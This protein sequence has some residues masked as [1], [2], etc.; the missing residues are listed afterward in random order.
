VLEKHCVTD[1]VASCIGD[2][3]LVAP[4]VFHRVSN[5]LSAGCA[6][7]PCLTDAWVDVG[8]NLAAQRCK[9][10]H[11]VV[12]LSPE[13]CVAVIEGKSQIGNIV[14]AGFHSQAM[15]SWSLA[16]GETIDPPHRG[17]FIDVING[18]EVDGLEGRSHPRGWCVG[19]D[20]QEGTNHQG[21]RNLGGTKSGSQVGCVCCQDWNGWENQEGQDSGGQA[22]S[23]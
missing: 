6:W 22:L 19:P 21:P 13:V 1:A 10:V 8:F 11:I 18:E 3:D 2:V 20:Y 9:G 5:V 12:V 14:A 16:W 23:Q 15:H 4:V 17:I 7:G